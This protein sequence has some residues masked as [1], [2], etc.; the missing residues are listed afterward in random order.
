GLRSASCVAERPPELA[1]VPDGCLRDDESS[2]RQP[3]VS[4]SANSAR[5][6][7]RFA[8]RRGA[9]RSATGALGPC[10]DTN[11]GNEAA[12]CPGLHGDVKCTATSSAPRRRVHRDVECTRRRGPRLALSTFR[13]V[14]VPDPNSDPP[15][16]VR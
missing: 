4:T 14:S 3:V 15:S 5:R 12:L 2:E 10:D 13:G 6:A 8:S 9:V 7:R 11:G 16:L 1:L